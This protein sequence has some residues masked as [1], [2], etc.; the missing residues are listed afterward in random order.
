MRIDRL[1]SS[2]RDFLQLAEKGAGGLL[3]GLMS[4]SVD[5]RDGWPAAAQPAAS[6]TDALAARRAQMGAQPI[7]QTPSAVTSSS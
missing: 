5:A 6:P 4:A 2:R 3:V 7:Q 1:H